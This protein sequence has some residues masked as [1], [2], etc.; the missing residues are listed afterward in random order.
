MSDNYSEELMQRA[1]MQEIGNSQERSRPF[2]LLAAHVKVTIDGNQ[3]CVLYGEN[4]QDGVTG[5]GDSPD[6]ASRD[7]DKN[8]CTKLETKP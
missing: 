2:M 3:W 4:L 6:A 8:W 5:F 1:A 7:F